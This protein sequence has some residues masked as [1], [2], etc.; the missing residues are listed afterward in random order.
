MQEK[1]YYVYILAN[2]TNAVVYIGVTND[3]MRRLWE[4]RNDMAD[5]FTKQYHVH[6]LM[7]YESTTDVN[8]AIAR[9]KQLK[10]WPR[11]KKNDL[12]ESAN[13][14]WKDLAGD[15]FTTLPAAH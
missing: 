8:E 9:E 10:G 15:W 3:L 6:K 12:I 14:A 1:N 2:K 11:A 13:P 7:Y 5:G 4:H